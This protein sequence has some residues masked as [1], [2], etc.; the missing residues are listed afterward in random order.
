MLAQKY[1]RKGCEVY[2]AYILDNKESE[3]R[4]E[5][6]PVVYE[7]VDV[8]LEELPGLPPER[9]IEFRIELVPGTAPISIVL[10]RMA[11][12]KLKELKVQLQELTDKGFTRP[13]YLP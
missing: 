6:V 3:K 13:S 12:T 11:P 1:V 10:C 8:F 7:F 5:S 4:F 9:E 2:L